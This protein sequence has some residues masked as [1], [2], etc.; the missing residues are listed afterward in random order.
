MSFIAK[1]QHGALI[2]I[3]RENTRRAEAWREVYESRAILDAVNSPSINPS[4]GWQQ[5]ECDYFKVLAKARALEASETE[6][7]E[8]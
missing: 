3:E 5:A 2:D 4:R 7:G 8:S 1:A 6:G